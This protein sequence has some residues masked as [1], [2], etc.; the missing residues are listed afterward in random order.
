MINLPDG[1][2]WFG[3]G[4]HTG[5][6]GYDNISYAIGQSLADNPQLQSW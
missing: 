2:I 6:A 3:N 5:T 4:A 1:R